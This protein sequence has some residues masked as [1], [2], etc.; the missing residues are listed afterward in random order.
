LDLQPLAVFIELLQ[1]FLTIYEITIR[2]F[3]NLHVMNALMSQLFLVMLMYLSG[4][5]LPIH[6]VLQVGLRCLQLV[7]TCFKL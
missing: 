1:G 4:I 7:N 2:G 5:G 3:T 6:D